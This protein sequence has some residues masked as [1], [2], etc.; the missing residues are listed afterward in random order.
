MGDTPRNTTRQREAGAASRAETRRQLI[1]AAKELFS[2]QGYSATTVTKIARRAGVSLQT[3]YLACGSK[4]E[5]LQVVLSQ[6]LS[7]TPSGIG[8][9]YLTGLRAQM[10][11]AADETYPEPE[12]TLRAFTRLFR[13]LAERAE[14]WWRVYRDAAAIDPE[15]ASDW[16][17]LT[18]Q[19]RIATAALLQDLADAQLPP[20]LTRHVLVDTAWAIASPETCQLLINHAGYTLDDYERWMADTLSRVVASPA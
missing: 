20:G 7:G 10:A 9:D 1:A 15:I 12:R 5:L 13:T 16:A 3:L 6:A 19:R 18:A 11:S 8:P 4:R 14:P 2:E 17:T